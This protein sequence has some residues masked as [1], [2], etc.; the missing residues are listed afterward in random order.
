MEGNMDAK[1]FTGLLV[2]VALTVQIIATAPPGTLALIEIG[3]LGLLYA[4]RRRR[5]AAI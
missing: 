3:L 4:V 1:K 2:A 5:A